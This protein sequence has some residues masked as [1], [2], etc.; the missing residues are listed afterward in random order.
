MRAPLASYD[1]G[2]NGR[3]S[4]VPTRLRPDHRAGE[5]QVPHAVQCG[6]LDPQRPPLATALTITNGP[7]RARARARVRAV[8]PF[9]QQSTS[10]PP[11][12]YSGDRRVGLG[13]RGRDPP[14]CAVSS[15]PGVCA[16]RC[17][18][19][20]PL[21]LRPDVRPTRDVPGPPDAR[22][23]SYA[24]CV[25]LATLRPR[26]RLLADGIV[27]GRGTSNAVIEPCTYVRRLRHA[28]SRPELRPGL[29]TGWGAHAHADP[30][31]SEARPVNHRVWNYA[32]RSPEA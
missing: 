9:L 16:R 24:V 18:R 12:L 15:K 20:S 21:G 3:P 2:A 30:G 31:A 27:R 10:F 1:V 26:S 23:E 8:R 7:F 4:C 17:A 29:G 11:A 5:T 25:C 22:S 32:V 14:P 13:G 19:Y 6:G 28:R